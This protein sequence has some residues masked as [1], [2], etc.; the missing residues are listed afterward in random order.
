MSCNGGKQLSPRHCVCLR[1]VSAPP[2]TSSGR[3]EDGARLARDDELGCSAGQVWLSRRW[4]RPGRKQL[5]LRG[6][7]PKPGRSA[8]G[9]VLK[10]G[11]E[12]QLL[13]KLGVA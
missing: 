5:G 3:K 4:I 12:R 9:S 8:P 2:A 13:P 6:A 1:P 11:K 7:L 10:K